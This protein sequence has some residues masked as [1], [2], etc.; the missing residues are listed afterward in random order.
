[1]IR[2]MILML[3][4]AILS[5]K[6]LSLRSRSY[7]LFSR[8]ES[9][10]TANDVVDDL[11][12]KL[13]NYSS[14]TIIKNTQKTINID[15][16]RI[17]RQVD[18]IKKLLNV[19]DFNVDI[20]FCSETKIRELNDEWRGKRKSTD[21]LSFPACDF[22]SPG[23]FVNDP[24]FEHLKHLGDIA[25]SPLYVQRQCIKDLKLYNKNK[26]EYLAE[27]DAGVSKAMSTVFDVNKRISY[28]IIHGMIH[29][30]GYD[31]ETEK[32]WKQMTK[33]EKEVLD[34]IHNLNIFE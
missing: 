28:L 32:Q 31:H 20:W 13:T 17:H 22:T 11:K 30:L 3:S 15:T 16:D 18:E 6:S 33:K 5:T 29:L 7:R 27:T 34:K 4:L 9:K 23:K 19:A 2:L 25:I 14:T 8:V 26:E 24:T 1:M 12:K 10:F 21:V